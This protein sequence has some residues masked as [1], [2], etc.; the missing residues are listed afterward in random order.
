[1]YSHQS[2]NF[3]YYKYTIDGVN[4]ILAN[5][6]IFVIISI[7]LGYAVDDS[8]I[9]G[10]TKCILSVLAIIPLTYYIGMAITSISAQSSFAVGAILNA[11]FGSM[12]EVI[13]FIIML[14]KGRDTG[15]ECYQ[16]L[17]KS[18]LT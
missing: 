1:M 8:L 18:S 6:L 13:L 10:M 3:Y 11:T 15:Q 14:K 2:V 12:V 16:E 4:V 5:L 9:D 17:V 7:V